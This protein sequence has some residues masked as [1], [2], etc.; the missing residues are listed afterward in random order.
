MVSF[1]TNVLSKILWWQVAYGN[2]M[3][4]CNMYAWHK[5]TTS[6]EKFILRESKKGEWCAYAVCKEVWWKMVRFPGL[7]GLAITYLLSCPKNAQCTFCKNVHFAYLEVWHLQIYSQGCIVS[8]I[9]IGQ[10]I[11]SNT[12]F[13][14]LTTTPIIASTWFKIFRYD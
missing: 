6:K 14:S 10:A 2:C 8:Q 1:D 5:V 12:H 11:V 9:F 7:F 13:M 4:V 3:K